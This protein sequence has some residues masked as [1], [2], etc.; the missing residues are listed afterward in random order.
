MPVIHGRGATV[1][2]E[3]VAE[4]VRVNIGNVRPLSYSIQQVLDAIAGHAPTVGR[5]E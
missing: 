3:G 2:G 4:S 1:S 5:L